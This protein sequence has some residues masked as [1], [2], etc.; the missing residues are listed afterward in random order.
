MP[1]ARGARF[2]ANGLKWDGSLAPQGLQGVEVLPGAKD[3]PFRMTTRPIPGQLH[4]RDAFGEKL[5]LNS[6]EGTRRGFSPERLRCARK[7]R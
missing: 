1:D 4:F 7:N 5:W 3:A 6:P 2:E